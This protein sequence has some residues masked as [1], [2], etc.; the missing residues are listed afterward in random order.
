[1]GQEGQEGA[2]GGR[3]EP[4]M[5]SEGEGGQGERRGGEN[6]TVGANTGLVNLASLP[7]LL[8]L[9]PSPALGMTPL[10]WSRDSP[11]LIVCSNSL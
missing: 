8:P 9:P 10:R 1:M 7:S 2:G 11:P 5:A 3:R 4:R 6:N